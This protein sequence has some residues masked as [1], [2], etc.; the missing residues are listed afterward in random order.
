MEHCVPGDTLLRITE[1]ARRLAVSRTAVYRLINRGELETV[2]IGSAVRFSPA[3]IEHYI[4]NATRAI[5]KG[6]KSHHAE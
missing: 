1:V 5:A 6:E 2:R 3:T 4:A